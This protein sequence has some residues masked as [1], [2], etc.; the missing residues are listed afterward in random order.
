MPRRPRLFAPGLPQHLVQRGV[1][2]Q[3]V[4]FD[5]PDCIRYLHFLTEA[6]DEYGCAVHCYA[7]MPN[8]VHLLMTPND[9]DALPNTMHSVN[10][11]YVR[12][13]NDKYAR[14]GALWAGRY[15]TSL[16]STDRYLYACFRYIELNPV[17][18]GIVSSPGQYRW[19]SYNFHAYGR[20]DR[21]VSP[22]EHYLA[23]GDSWLCRRSVYRARFS[24]GL[25]AEELGGIRK[26]TLSGRAFG[27]QA[28]TEGLVTAGIIP[29]RGRRK[30]PRN[31]GV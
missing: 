26:A 29:P 9:V 28:F 17:R 8:H 30:A 27:D 13:V 24:D 25:S 31:V 23:L 18:A 21:L 20:Y 19:S 2:R 6:A 7:L 4:Y 11:R 3:S 12:H 16:V 15:K 1:N 22:H 5:D 14:V 10:V